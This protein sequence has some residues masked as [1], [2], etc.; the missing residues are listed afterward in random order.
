MTTFTQSEIEAALDAAQ[1]EF[2][3]YELQPGE[4]TVA[5][6]AARGKKELTAAEREIMRGISAGRFELLGFRLLDGRR[7]KVYRLILR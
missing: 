1:D 2:G 5:T 7:R 3:E 6:Y 4:F